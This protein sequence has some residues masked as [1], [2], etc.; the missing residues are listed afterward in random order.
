MASKRLPEAQ[1]HHIEQTVT[2]YLDKHPS[3]SNTELRALAGITY[4]Q[5]TD[6][7]NRMLEAGKLRRTGR[8][9][10]IKYVRPED[11]HR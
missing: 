3:I 6:F 10:G 5:A 9:A 7:F 2:A 4:D 11:T 8:T 1:I